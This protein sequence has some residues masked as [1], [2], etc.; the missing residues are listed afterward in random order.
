MSKSR[1]KPNRQA[2][3]LIDSMKLKVK[4]T[5]SKVHD[6]GYRPFLTEI[7]MRLAL[8]G[9]EVYND[10]EDTR[11]AVVALV[12]GDEQR[13]ARFCDSAQKELPQLAVVD[14]VRCEDYADDIMP[15]WQFA[16]ISTATQMNKAIPLLLAVKENTDKIPEM[17][18][19]LKAVRLNTDIIPEIRDDLK[20]VRLNTDTI[21]E[22]RDD[23][24]AAK[25]N[26]E[27]TLDEIRGLRVDIQ[28]GYA[29]NF[30]Q[31]QA[32]VRAIKDRLGMP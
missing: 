19:D 28:P 23:L 21:P 24:K 14:R 25:K 2:S 18:H 26:T 3:N 22:I 5:G 10:E 15:L 12:E 32:D 4:I 9:F 13:V 1:K 31:I 8:R 17:S 16:S 11:Q 27:A 6:V 7:A 29:M 20:A 30:R